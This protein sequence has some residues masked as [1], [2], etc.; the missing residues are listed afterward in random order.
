MNPDGTGM[1]VIG[2]NLR[3]SYEQTVS[4]LGDVFQNDN[5][6]P[7]ACR[8][9]FLMEYADMGYAKNNGLS[10]WKKARRFNFDMT[11]QQT[12]AVAEWEVKTMS[13]TPAGDVYGGGSPTGI[14]FYENGIMEDKLKGFL[15]SCE[16]ARNVIFGYKP[17]VQGA[18]FKLER[19]DFITTSP[20]KAL[21]VET[22]MG[23]K[24]I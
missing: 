2:H 19:E 8:T 11:G 6:D 15:M 23:A 16:P 4:S 3:N 24:I 9:S 14:A 1:R 22:S 18:G 21:Q 5:D 20:M 13:V 12:T 7:P 17:E 10:H